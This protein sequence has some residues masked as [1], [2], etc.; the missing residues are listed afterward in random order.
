M[1]IKS[2]LF[3]ISILGTGCVLG[4][5]VAQAYSINLSDA[6]PEIGAQITSLNSLPK[7]ERDDLHTKH[8]KQMHTNK[9]QISLL[10][11][12]LTQIKNTLNHLMLA[13]KNESGNVYQPGVS[14]EEII[15]GVTV[16]EPVEDRQFVD[17]FSSYLANEVSSSEDDPESTSK[18]EQSFE[19]ELESRRT[20]GVSLLSSECKATLCKIELVFDDETTRERYTGLGT[21]II[22]WDGQAFYHQSESEPNTMIY[23]VAKEGY[24]L[25]MPEPSDS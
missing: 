2:L 13:Q 25:A 21:S 12:Q 4:G 20:T 18:I 17:H 10:E 5:F 7:N 15:T 24:D 9:T 16:E 3:T 1:N 14:E 8:S 11:Q 22:P 23:Y 19:A 6:E